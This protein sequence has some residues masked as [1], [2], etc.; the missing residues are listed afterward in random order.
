MRRKEFQQPTIL[1]YDVLIIKGLRRNQ[2]FL[3]IKVVQ[4]QCHAVHGQLIKTRI[5][6]CTT[7]SIPASIFPLT[8][9]T[10]ETISRI[11]TENERPSEE[12]IISISESIPA[13]MSRS[14]RPTYLN[15]IVE[16]TAGSI[17]ASIFPIYDWNDFKVKVRPTNEFQLR[18]KALPWYQLFLFIK[19][20]RTIGHGV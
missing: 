12:P 20:V 17:P 16:C 2:L 10:K 13:P 14:S 5:A 8:Q 4:P 9:Y 19:V 3:C 11:S 15:F 7:G 6:E 18:T 1:A